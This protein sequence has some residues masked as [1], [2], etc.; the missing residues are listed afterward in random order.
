[1][2]KPGSR[3]RRQ[4]IRRD[5]LFFAVP[6]LI[7][8]AAG[9]VVS[10]Q[11]GYDGL[12]DTLWRVVRSPEQLSLLT[13]SNILSLGVFIVG[14]TIALVAVFTLKKFYASTL[15]ILQDHRLITHGI[16]RVVRHPIYF[17]VLIAV[18]GPPLYGPSVW[19]C[20]V[21]ALLIPIF[22]NRIR[23]EEQLLAEEFGEAYADYRRST[24]RLIPFT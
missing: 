13:W 18:F 6:A 24:P 2:S 14:L 16:Y 21:M 7:V 8:F 1:V 22:L 9:L 23:M 10:G 11:D 12:V 17:G 4:A 15:V 5:L 3:F 19:G 20:L